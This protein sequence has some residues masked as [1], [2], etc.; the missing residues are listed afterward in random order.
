MQLNSYPS[1]Y[2]L[3]HKALEHLFD[4]PVLIQEKIDGSQFSFGL[5]NGELFFRS[6]GAVIFAEN[7][8]TMFSKGVNTVK[9]LSLT[10]G[11][12][13]RGELLDKP[14]HN[15]LAYDRVPNGN[16]ILFDIESS[17]STFLSEEQ[18]K[19]EASRLGLEVV[20]SYH[21]GEFPSGQ[22]GLNLIQGFLNSTSVLGGQKVEG[23]VIKNYSQFGPDKKTLMGKFVSEA[24]KE[25]H[26]KT[27]GESNP[28][29]KDIIQKIGLSLKTEARFNKAVQHLRERDE[30]TD[31]P[32]D[33]GP[34]MRELNLDLL[35]EETDYIK[36]E[37]YKWASK[38]IL[39]V[40]TSGFAEWYKDRLLKM[41]FDLG[42]DISD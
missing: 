28:G 18:L 14:K 8:P 5:V 20:P 15:T 9:N 12:I 16:V 35:K 13:Y 24:F 40:A 26:K 2:N 10:E 33:I 38:D 19:E 37:L 6:K 7:P 39:R 23:V 25:V 41:Q 21:F 36:D 1:I 3:G 11:Y 29:G 27:W 17:D 4:N 32:K 34:L 31:S 22:D 30:I 42:E